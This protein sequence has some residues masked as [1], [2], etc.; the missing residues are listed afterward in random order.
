M[1]SYIILAALIADLVGSTCTAQQPVF[2]AASVKAVDPAT[3]A[4]FSMTGGPGT[5]D[6]GRIHFVRAT[7][8]ELLMS[9]YDV[10]TDQI[11]GPSWIDDSLGASAYTI[12]ATMPANTTKEQFRLMLQNMLGSAS[13]W[14]CTTKR[15]IFRATI[16][17]WQMAGPSSRRL[18]R[19]LGQRRLTA[20]AGCPWA[21]TVSRFFRQGLEFPSSCCRVSSG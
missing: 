8:L 9:A 11:V 3:S 4:P 7:M 14:W 16:L 12:D 21:T 19:N 2:D 17:L 15:R 1:R 13:I 18:P 10:A 20:P 5:S 6:P